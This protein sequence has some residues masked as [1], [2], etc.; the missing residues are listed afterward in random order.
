VAVAIEAGER[1]FDRAVTFHRGTN[2]RVPPHDAPRTMF[3]VSAALTIQKK[4]CDPGKH[5]SPPRHFA[6][7]L[8]F[9]VAPAVARHELFCMKNGNPAAVAAARRAIPCRGDEV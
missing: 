7:A 2:Q 8:T 6:Q 5:L 4:L 1:A 9:G 3:K